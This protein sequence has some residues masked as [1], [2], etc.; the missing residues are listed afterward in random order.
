MMYSAEELSKRFGINDMTG[1]QREL[2]EVIGAGA[3]LKLCEALVTVRC[4]SREMTDC[5]A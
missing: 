5:R 3:A 1:L 2:A 4:I